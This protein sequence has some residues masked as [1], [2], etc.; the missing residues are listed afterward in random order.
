MPVNWQEDKILDT[1]EVANIW[2]PGVKAGHIASTGIPSGMPTITTNE[3]ML[4]LLDTQVLLTSILDP[5]SC[6]PPNTRKIALSS[7]SLKHSIT[8]GM[9][10]AEDAELI[11]PAAAELASAQRMKKTMVTKMRMIIMIWSRGKMIE[12]WS[13]GKT[14]MKRM[15][16]N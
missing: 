9:Y 14:I 1:D 5:R 16:L 4:R 13:S 15:I 11:V 2:F 12:I 6:F 7:D 10:I 8:D 3:L